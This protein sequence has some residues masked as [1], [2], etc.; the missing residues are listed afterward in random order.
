MPNRI[1][2]RTR[3]CARC[4][5][6]FLLNVDIDGVRKQFHK[7]KYCFDCSPFGGGNR[8]T[9]EKHGATHKLC[10]TCGVEKPV[11]DF[12]QRARGDYK[13]SCRVC[14]DQEGLDRRRLYKVQAV[15][16]LG[17]KCQ[18]CGYSRSY[19]ALEFHHVD[20]TQKE[21]T[22]ST[23]RRSFESSKA[24]LG[25][26][27]LV[28][29]NCHR[30]EHVRLLPPVAAGQLDPH[31]PQCVRCH[32]HKAGSEFTHRRGGKRH[33]WCNTCRTEY[34]RGRR[35]EIK[36]ETVDYKGGGCQMCGYSKCLDALEFHHSDPTQKDLGVAEL[37]K[38]L[39]KIK[40][41]VDKCILVC[42]NCHRE[43]HEALS[44]TV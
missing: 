34:Q 5:Q 24:E 38:R 32:L 4:G 12:Y 40:S 7:R 30:E 26:C 17:G 31:G 37:R 3:A 35:G 11:S 13:S 19:A 25:K 39:S 27:V 36:Q 16:Y 22:F 6:H 9:L 42:S 1:S 41:E 44:H 2:A 43:L 8:S 14:H 21:F 28:C 23:A 20:P 15:A 10:S 29:S 18:H 33:P